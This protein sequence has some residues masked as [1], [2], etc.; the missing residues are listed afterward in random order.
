[1]Q[2]DRNALNMTEDCLML[3]MYVPRDLSSPAPMSRDSYLPSSRK[4]FP[5]MIW[6]HSGEFTIGSEIIY[7]SEVLSS[8]G[9]VIIIMINYRLSMFGF[10]DSGNATATGNQRLWDQ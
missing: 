5:V 3:N 8:F 10:L 2:Q 6:I 1:M 7:R 9:D 4:L